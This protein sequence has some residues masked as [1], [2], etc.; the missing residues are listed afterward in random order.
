MI[1]MNKVNVVTRSLGCI[2]DAIFAGC[3]LPSKDLKSTLHSQKALKI[4]VPS[5]GRTHWA[6]LYVMLR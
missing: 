4:T 2:T 1:T 3:C 5:E 6:C